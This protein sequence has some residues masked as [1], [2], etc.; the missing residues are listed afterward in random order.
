ENSVQK[1]CTSYTIDS[2]DIFN[3]PYA[4]NLSSF[5]KLINRLQSMHPEASRDKI[6]EALQQVRKDNKGM[7]CGLSISTIEERTSAIL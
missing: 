3:S 2:S 1:T 4:L 6:V 7:L 5:T